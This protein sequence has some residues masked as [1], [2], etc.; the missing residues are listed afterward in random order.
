MLNNNIGQLQF[1]WNSDTLSPVWQTPRCWVFHA[2]AEW[3]GESFHHRKWRQ[4]LQ[5]FRMPDVIWSI[6]RSEEAHGNPQQRKHIRL[7]S[8]P[9][10]INVAGK[11]KITWLPTVECRPPLAQNVRLR[12]HLAKQEHWGSTWSPTLGRKNTNV[13]NVEIYLVKLDIWNGTCSPTVGRSCKLAQNV[14]SHLV[15][16]EHRGST[17]SPTLRR[18]YTNVQ[19]AEIYLVKLHIWKCTCSQWGEATYVHTIVLCIFTSRPSERSR[20][21]T[22]LTKAKSIR[23]VQLH[24]NHKITSSKH[25]HSG[26]KPHH[27]TMCTCSS[28]WKMIF[29]THFLWS[30][31]SRS[32]ISP[33]ICPCIHP[34]F[35]KYVST[36]SSYC[37]GCRVIKDTGALYWTKYTLCSVKSVWAKQ[38]LWKTI[39]ALTLEKNHTQVQMA[40]LLFN[41]KGK[42]Y[43]PYPQALWGEDTSLQGVREDIQSTGTIEKPPSHSYWR[44][45]I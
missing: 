18:K 17:W 11:L 38:E 22:F 12:S 39:F 19:N 1:Q 40:R 5:L 43:Q 3:Y 4:N 37:I 34:F 20:Q 35:P 41:H 42:P 6:R 26:E 31:N 21:N 29:F 14:I 27:C 13:Q 9:V 25:L 8:V 2:K 15:K 23:M 7:R 33:I 45:V 32:V 30:S 44:K 24:F 10:D 36:P 16:Q 28:V